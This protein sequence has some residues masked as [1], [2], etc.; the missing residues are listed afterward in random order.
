MSAASRRLLIKE[1]K[2][3]GGKW[4]AA[5]HLTSQERKNKD[6]VYKYA[7]KR[8]LKVRNMGDLCVVEG[9]D[10]AGRVHDVNIFVGLA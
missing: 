9:Y 3:L 6:V 7:D 2:C 4:K 5:A 10:A 8:G 1:I